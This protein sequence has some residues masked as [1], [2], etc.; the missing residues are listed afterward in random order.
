VSVYLSVAPPD[1]FT[2]WNDAQWE[3]W[4]RAHPW[5]AAERVCSRAEWAAFLYH[6]REHCPGAGKAIAP[7]YALLVDERPLTAEE[8]S[9]LRNTLQAG[10]AEL[11]SKPAHTIPGTDRR[12]AGED[13]EA[14]V[15]AARARLGKE[16]SL[17]DVWADL[18]SRVDRL[19]E[20][21]VSRGRGIYFG[22]V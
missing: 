7:L 22:N 18:F 11:D 20:N 9:D 17:G 15:A 21:A 12:F 5:E 16:P 19:L 8:T 13:L 10:R 14:M 4:L 2:R 3:R 6:L 1:G